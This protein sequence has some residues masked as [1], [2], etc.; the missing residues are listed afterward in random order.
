MAKR[1]KTPKTA[2]EAGARNSKRTQKAV[3]KMLGHKKRKKK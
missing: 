1:T 2:D 3:Q